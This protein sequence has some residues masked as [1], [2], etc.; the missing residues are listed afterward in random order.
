MISFKV[1]CNTLIADTQTMPSHTDAWSRDMLSLKVACNQPGNMV[2]EI[3]IPGGP[4]GYMG[5]WNGTSCNGKFPEAFE[6]CI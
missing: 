5:G 3:A 6:Y 2:A 1:A 4:W